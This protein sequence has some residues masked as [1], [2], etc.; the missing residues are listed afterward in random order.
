MRG[1]VPVWLALAGQGTHSFRAEMGV[2]RTHLPTFKR[3]HAALKAGRDTGPHPP[4]TGKET[5]NTILPTL[6]RPLSTITFFSREVCI[7]P[8]QRHFYKLGE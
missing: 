6:N 2:S 7:E 8:V 4:P 5:Q 3:E 1:R